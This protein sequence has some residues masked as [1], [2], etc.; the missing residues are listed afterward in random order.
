VT[1]HSD[2]DTIRSVFRRIARAFLWLAVVAGS[3]IAAACPLCA[4]NL[5][6]DVYQ[7]NPTQLGRGFFWSIIFMMAL[8][9]VTV[10]VVAVRIMIAKRRRGRVVEQGAE[11]P[12]FP[13]VS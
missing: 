12:A 11:F 5:S 10:A 2:C 3:R 9:F 13:E 4:E 7:K 1:N 8:P 6:N